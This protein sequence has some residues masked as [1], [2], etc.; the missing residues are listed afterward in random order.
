MMLPLVSSQGLPSVQG[1]PRDEPSTQNHPGV[2]VPECRSSAGSPTASTPRGSFWRARETKAVIALCVKNVQSYIQPTSSFGNFPAKRL[3]L[4][5][6]RALLKA[7]PVRDP[8]PLQWGQV[9]ALDAD[10]ARK[11]FLV[12]QTLKCFLCGGRVCAPLRYPPTWSNTSLLSVSCGNVTFLISSRKR[13]H[14]FMEQS[15]AV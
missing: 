7:A 2:H 14:L 9:L 8:P 10:G 13:R 15:D 1:E 4:F 3:G 5:G 11:A 12:G 6:K